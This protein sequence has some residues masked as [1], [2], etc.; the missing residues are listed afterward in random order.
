MSPEERQL[1]SSLVDRINTAAS[2][3]RD[4]EA[5]ALIAELEVT[6][7]Q[8]KEALQTFIT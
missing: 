5:E 8:T 7:I 3:P 4:A 2:A 6:F 1:I